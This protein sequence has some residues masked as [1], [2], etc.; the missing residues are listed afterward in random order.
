MNNKYIFFILLIFNF[1]LATTC[2]DGTYSSSTGRGTCSHHGGVCSGEE[3][4]NI[5]HLLTAPTNLSIECDNNQ[6]INL[7]WNNSTYGLFYKIYYSSTCSS[8]YL[9]LD[10]TYSNYYTNIFDRCDI[11]FKIK[12]CDSIYC[13]NY[14][15]VVKGKNNSNILSNSSI[16]L[17]NKNLSIFDGAGSLISPNENCYGCN[18]DVV[19]MHEHNG[20]NS[21]VVFQWLYDKDTCNQINITSE[22]NIGDVIIKS[23]IWNQQ[24]IQNAKKV[25]LN[26]MTPITIKRPDDNHKWT[27][28]SITT[29][30]PLNFSNMIYASCK[31]SNNTKKIENESNINKNLVNLNNHYFWSGTGSLISIAKNRG[32][33]QFGID[34]DYAITLKNNK[35]LTSFQWYASSFCPKLKIENVKIHDTESNIKNVNVSIKKWDKKNWSLN[36]CSS[37]LPCVLEAPKGNGYYVIKIMSDINTIKSGI[38]SAKCIK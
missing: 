34:K 18:K 15:K 38:L 28:F 26:S 5:Y 10:S 37:T 36:K 9:Y 14:S 6:N 22:E 23:K 35:S 3:N 11:C 33:N 16:D 21:T 12:S 24:S 31:T 1:S 30:K 7:K 29:T 25:E 17:D 4:N 27:I 32:S 8:S 13:S 2:C 20:K 19:K